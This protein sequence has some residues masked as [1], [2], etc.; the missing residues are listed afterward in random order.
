MKVSRAQAEA[1]RERVI[2]ASS[3]LFRERGFAGIGLND[4]MQAAGL[5]RGGFYGQFESKQDLVKQALARALQENIAR[6][7]GVVAK[8]KEDP[9]RQFV[10]SYLSDIHA[11]QVSEGCALAALAPDAEREGESVRAVFGEGARDLARLIETLLPVEDRASRSDRAWACL[12]ALVGAIVLSRAVADE[13]DA[14]AIRRSTSD[15]LLSRGPD[16]GARPPRAR[17]SAG[18][19]S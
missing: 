13:A 4:L 19:K 6:W 15:L 18:K 3:R 10:R 17:T 11:R 5:T 12:A 8:A 1:N 2:D 14:K 7:E 9:L 16:Q